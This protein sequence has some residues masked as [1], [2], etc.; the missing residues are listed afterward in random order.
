MKTTVIL[1]M[2]IICLYNIVNTHAGRYLRY[3]PWADVQI[4]EHKKVNAAVEL[5]LVLF[6]LGHHISLAPS[7]WY[8]Y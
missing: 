3:Q 5:N 1:C 4:C 6:D 8:L 2:I 7:C